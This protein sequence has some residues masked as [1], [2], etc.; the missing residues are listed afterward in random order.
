MRRTAR[1]HLQDF[2]DTVG[3]PDNTYGTFLTLTG[4][5]TTLTELFWHC[6]A[7]RQ[8]LQNFLGTVGRNT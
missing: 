1:Q 8:R 4:L 5:P 6:R 7:A 2:F 3:E